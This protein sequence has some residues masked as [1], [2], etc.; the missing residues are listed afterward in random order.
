MNVIDSSAWLE[1]VANGPGAAYFAKAVEDVP[2]LVVPSVVVYE[3]FKRILQQRSETEA[4]QV[5]AV[6]RQGHIVDLDMAIAMR[7][8][9]LSIQ[10][11]LPMADAVILATT[12]ACEG[13]LW[14]Q[15]ADFENIPGVRYHP[16]ETP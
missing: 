7:A 9:T 2:K 12:L 6:M 3:V 8:A 15:D 4:L 14:T 10:H 13:T 16:R 5:I 1:Y 11:R